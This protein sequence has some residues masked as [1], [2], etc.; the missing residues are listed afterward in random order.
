M[1]RARNLALGANSPMMKSILPLTAILSTSVIHAKNR[2]LLVHAFARLTGRIPCPLPISDASLCQASN[3]L[4][5]FDPK[6][7]ICPSCR[8]V[9]RPCPPLI[10]LISCTIFIF[11][12]VHVRVDVERIKASKNV[13]STAPS[14]CFTNADFAALFRR[15]TLPLLALRGCVHL[16]CVSAENAVFLLGLRSL[17]CERT[18]FSVHC[19]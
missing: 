3:A 18:R 13:K 6:T 2:S 11:W 1:T 5:D 16:K 14:G 4:A 10:F 8:K 7:V 12:C 15:F 19:A 9:R 17:L